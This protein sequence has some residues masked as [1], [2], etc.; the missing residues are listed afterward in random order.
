LK[1]IT[2]YQINDKVLDIKEMREIMHEHDYEMVEDKG[3]D[4]WLFKY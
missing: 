2:R 4:D 3:N 1:N